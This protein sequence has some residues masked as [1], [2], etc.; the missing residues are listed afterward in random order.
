MKK[1]LYLLVSLLAAVMLCLGANICYANL[2]MIVD[3]VN[4]YQLVSRLIDLA[5]GLGLLF[6]A[7]VIWFLSNKIY[8]APR[9]VKNP[10][11]A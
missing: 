8:H 10:F 6:G 3:G 4:S 7:I 1:P 9:T 11:A 2:S 5:V